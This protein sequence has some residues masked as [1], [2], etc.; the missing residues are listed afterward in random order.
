VNLDLS[1]LTKDHRSF[2]MPPD[3]FA[4]GIQLT[5]ELMLAGEKAYELC[6]QVRQ[7]LDMPLLDGLAFCRQA[8]LCIWTELP[9]DRAAEYNKTFKE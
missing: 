1:K 3:D 8:M 6:K 4:A 2:R 9:G 5:A 7:L